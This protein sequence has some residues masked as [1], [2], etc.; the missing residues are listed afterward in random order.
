[1]KKG[2]HKIEDLAHLGKADLH[3]HS[4]YSDGQPSI[5][6]ILDYVEK[7]TDLNIIA[8][9][10]HDT[11]EGAL[12]AKKIMTTKKYRFELV[13]GEEV[14]SKD[15]HILGL[16]L[17]EKVP[18]GHSAHHTIEK[19][20]EQGGIAIASHPFM[21][22]RWRNPNITLMDGIGFITLMREKKNLNGLE[23]VNAT[24]TL[25]EEN[26][27]AAFINKTI[28]GKAETGSSDAHILEAI[29]KGYTLF[30]GKTSTDLYHAIRHHQ[31]QAMY[32]KWTLLALFRYLFFF[33]PKGLRMAWYTFQRGRSAKRPQIVNI[34]KEIE[35]EIVRTDGSK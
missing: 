35:K 30:E 26:L 13:I 27:Q 9:T 20:R 6:E 34:P 4:N 21:H 31:T 16:F 12:L 25:A 3:I 10:D 23:I 28:V 32:D 29:G 19:I 14:T 17:K 18:G 8:I 15:G 7:S 1:M 22:T 2:I 11:I 5:E 24:P 33:I